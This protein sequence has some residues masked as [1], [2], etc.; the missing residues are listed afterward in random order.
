MTDDAG[1][2][3]RYL[4]AT[5][6]LVAA[7]QGSSLVFVGAT[8][9]LADI[10]SQTTV[11][12]FLW[13]YFGML[14]VS[15]V[16]GLG[17]ERI[18]GIAATGAGTRLWRIVRLRILTA[19]LNALALYALMRFI[20]VDLP[21]WTFL[22]AVVWTT[23]A[24]I[25]VVAFSVLRTRGS[26]VHEPSLWAAD[27]IAGSVAVLA[28]ARVGPS[29]IVLT[30]AAIETVTAALALR[31]AFLTDEPVIQ[32]A[33][34]IRAA[35]SVGFALLELSAVVYLRI[36]LFVVGRVLGPVLG[37]TYGLLSR[38]VD[39][40]IGVVTV[41]SL[42]MFVE[43]LGGGESAPGIRRR[44]LRSFPAV[45]GALGLAVILCTPILGHVIER[46]EPAEG[47][48]RILVAAFPLLAVGA[49]EVGARAADRRTNELLAAVG[50]G[51][52][53]NLVVNLVLLNEIGLNGAAWALLCAE[54]VQAVVLSLWCRAADRQLFAVSA[55]WA[56]GASLVLLAVTG[57]FTI[58]AGAVIGAAIVAIGILSWMFVRAR[59]VVTRN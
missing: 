25:Q 46:L 58:G 30:V 8:L 23:A 50:T 38:I 13:A 17:F 52:V 45:A 39:G 28:L 43:T 49:A 48:L 59:S 26:R 1:A 22:G 2:F 57:S 12:S 3:R 5:G 41:A 33:P 16:L 9:L 53:V 44:A 35:T 27:R 40:M 4:G 18:A 54:V 11:D 19:P 51:I 14:T 42:W 10:A 15:A 31:Y 7:R 6:G 36:D 29:A 55:V 37:A 47:T 34:A 20:R 21:V 56:L 32:E 24:Q